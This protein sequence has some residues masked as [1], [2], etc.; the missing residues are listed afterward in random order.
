MAE[1]TSS[2]DNC[3]VVVI[4]AGPYGLSVA[5]HLRSMGVEFRIFGSPMEFWLKHMPKGMHLKSEGFA[6]SLFDANGDFALRAYCKE[7]NLPYADTGLP[8]PL[9]TFS[10]YGL[11]FQKRYVPELEQRKVTS[12]QR[13]TDGFKVTLDS[14]EIV[15]TRRVVVAVGLTYYEYVPPILASLPKEAMTHSSKHNALDRFAGREVTIVGAGASA[16]D[17]AALLHEMG[18]TVQVIS[19]GSR[20]RFHDPPPKTKPSLL[21]RFQNPATGIGLGWKIW[22]CA[23]LPLVFRQMPEEFRIEKVKR[24]LG[25]APCWFTKEKVVGKVGLNVGVTIRSSEVRNGRARLELQESTGL[26]RTLESDHIIAATGYQYDVR[27]LT[28]LAQEIISDIK[29]VGDSPS[30]SANFES[31]VP[32]LYF[33]GVTAANT[34]GPLLRFAFGAGFAAPRLSRHLLR[35]ASRK[36][37]QGGLVSETESSKERDVVA[38]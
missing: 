1:R 38:Q 11:E 9:G 37:V 31:S 2:M 3:E 17:L 32:N 21:A 22:M 28:F 35:T 14:S 13:S 8:V 4:G 6:S 5:A 15:L 26:V 16:L 36:Y 19:R 34:F 27:R 33:V 12:V 29:R 23:N 20:I 10:S 24:I 7:N 30:L 18:A 25:P